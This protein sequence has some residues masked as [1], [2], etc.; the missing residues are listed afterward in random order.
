MASVYASSPD[1]QPA[2]HTRMGMSA[3]LFSTMP[4]RTCS[5]RYSQTSGSRKKL[6][7]LIRTVSKSGPNSSG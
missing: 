2:L 4:G 1:A 3:G 5:R 6:V 7:T